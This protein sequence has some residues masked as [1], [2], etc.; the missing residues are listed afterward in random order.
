MSLLSCRSALLCSDVHLSDDAPAL[1]D[2]FLAWLEQHCL[3]AASQPQWL[4]ILGDLFDAWI[5]DDQMLD[6]GANDIGARVAKTLSAISQAGVR[7]GL[8]HGNRDFLLAQGFAHAAGAELLADPTLL[9]IE[10]GPRIAITHGDALCTDDTDYQRFRAQVRESSWQL[11]FLARP[12]AQRA[13][14]ARQMRAESNVEKNAKPLAIMDV[15]TTAAMTCV[16]ALNADML[17]HGHTHR[18]GCTSLADG[19]P[20]W[21][22]P[23]WHSDTSGRIER[24][25]GLWADAS[26]VRALR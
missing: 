1:T 6:A 23:D 15:N 26:G 14:T 25:G 11:A 3:H 24:G 12:L 9:S 2:A 13:Q 19:R 17:L 10:N 7:V 16:Q 8:M 18:P 4:L 21:V 5:G 20:R 22:L